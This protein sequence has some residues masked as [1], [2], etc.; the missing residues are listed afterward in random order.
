MPVECPNSPRPSSDDLRCLFAAGTRQ[1]A[2]LGIAQKALTARADV[3]ARSVAEGIRVSRDCLLAALS[4]PRMPTR[5][6]PANAI[7]IR[8]GVTALRASALPRVRLGR[9]NPFATPKSSVLWVRATWLHRAQSG[10]PRRICQPGL[11]YRQLK[12]RYGV[13]PTRGTGASVAAN[14]YAMTAITAAFS[15]RCR[16]FTLSRVSAAVW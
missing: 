2:R 14:A 10:W 4:S 9:L 7:P 1:V 13:N 15:A 8:T 3:P 11:P 6:A 16:G 12:S 5:S